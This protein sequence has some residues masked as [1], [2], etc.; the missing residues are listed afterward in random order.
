MHPLGVPHPDRGEMNEPRDFRKT[1]SSARKC[2]RVD[3]Q[4]YGRAKTF[5]Q[6]ISKP[7]S[8]VVNV[9]A[10][11]RR[12]GSVIQRGQSM[13]QHIHSYPRGT[14]VV[15]QHPRGNGRKAGRFA[16]VEACLHTGS[17]GLAD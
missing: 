4:T 8:T 17:T 12:V 3:R 5:P 9:S 14:G 1:K 16:C 7:G 11:M 2:E 15:H 6:L 10:W 13:K